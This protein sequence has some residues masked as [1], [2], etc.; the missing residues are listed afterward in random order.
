LRISYTDLHSLHLTDL[1]AL[2]VFFQQALLSQQKEFHDTLDHL[3]SQH[4]N[5]LLQLT[6]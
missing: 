6:D 3:Q 5:E 1:H 4:S 2:S